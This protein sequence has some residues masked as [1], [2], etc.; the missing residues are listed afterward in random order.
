MLLRSHRGAGSRR[1]QAGACAMLAAI[2]YSTWPMCAS[3][4][5]APIYSQV[6]ERPI[7][8]DPV[9]IDSG[10][11]SG[12][13][14]S[15]GVRAYFGIPFAIPPVRALRWREPQPVPPWNGVLAADRT[16]PECIQSL[17]AHDINHYFGEEAI[18]EDCLY[19][20]VWAPPDSASGARRPVVVWIYGGGFTI[21]SASMANYSGE[22][23]AGKGVVY[24]SIAYRVGALG[25]L[26]HPALTV[27]SP[28]HS[29]G[30]VGFLDQIAALQWIQRNIEMFGG[31]PGNVTIMGQSAGSMSVSILQASPLARGLFHHVVGMS[32]STL[33]D[34]AVAGARALA[35]A[36]RDG[37]QLQEDLRVADLTAMRAVPADRIL[38]A[39]VAGRLHYGPVVD[40]YLL[41]ATPAKIFAAGKQSDVPTL[42]GFVHDESFSELGRV[43][44]LADFQA[45]AR[46]IYGDKADELL[47]LYPATND[48]QAARAARDAGRDSSVALEMRAWARAQTATGKAP[49]YAY[50][51]SRIHPYASGIT[52]SD[53]DPKTVGAY[54][55]GDV[56]YWLGTLDA[57]NIFRV[58]RDWTDAD[59]SLSE[60]MSSAIVNFAT[61]GNPNAARSDDWPIY[62]LKREQL[63][64]LDLQSRVISWP[65]SSKMD[66]FVKNAPIDRTPA[67]PPAPGRT[68]D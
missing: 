50:L 44:T 14:L 55:T 25:F 62:R 60:Y 9:K 65:D 24:V 59:R 30:D 26:A 38:A 51:F 20:N 36:E 53:H 57:L 7:C 41:P 18:S 3:E 23:L 21:G 48:A 32:G 64:E 4:A 28:H 19:L 67:P 37:E 22:S 40:G 29:S 17:R 58:T 68:R 33:A 66:F 31:D 42:I 1:I 52:F 46:K 43:L 15:S 2:L 35:S 16:A 45:R 11:V 63:R 61:T 34:D 6:R 49:V 47:K 27:E 12:K 8:G 5:A 54:H 10:L 13:L 39:Q 56:P